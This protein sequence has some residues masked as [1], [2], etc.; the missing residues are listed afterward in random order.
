MAKKKGAP[1]PETDVTHDRDALDDAHEDVL[2]EVDDEVVA[3][4]VAAQREAT[5]EDVAR[6]VRR[7]PRRYENDVPLASLVAFPGNPKDHDVGMIVESMRANGDYATLR[8]Q[9]WPDTP[10]YIL[11]G[12]GTREALEQ[13]GVTHVDV[14][15]LKVDPRTAR[16]IVLVD[17]RAAQAGGFRDDLLSAMLRE[18]LADFVDDGEVDGLYD[19]LHQRARFTP[20]DGG[21]APATP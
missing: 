20:L 16:R 7:V 15:W 9:D 5:R 17:N 8:V 10:P 1:A 12:H 13:L 19:A 21:T 4:G 18:Q 3:R 11:A 6:T 2:H 14:V